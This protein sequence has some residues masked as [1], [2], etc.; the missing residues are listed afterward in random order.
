MSPV[1][2]ERAR[3]FLGL[4]QSA[5]QNQDIAM[6]EHFE[7]SARKHKNKNFRRIKSYRSIF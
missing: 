6:R 4:E 3:L 5:L 7:L 2:K 1:R